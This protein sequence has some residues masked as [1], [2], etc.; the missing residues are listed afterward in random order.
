M[1]IFRD[2]DTIVLKEQDIIER[3]SLNSEINF[4]ELI[5]Y[6]LKFNLSQKFKLDNKIDDIND[7]EKNLVKLIESIINDYNEKVDELI[8]FKNDNK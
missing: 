1:E 8:K 3:Y 2:K 6:L 4:K 7:A 5:N